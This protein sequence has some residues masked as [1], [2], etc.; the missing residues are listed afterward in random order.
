MREM[1]NFLQK[2]ENAE[3]LYNCI[4]ICYALCRNKY[5][6]LTDNLV[7]RR[8][9]GRFRNGNGIRA[10]AKELSSSGPV[11]QNA[12]PQRYHPSEDIAESEIMMNE[13]TRLTPAETSRTIIEV[14]L[15]KKYMI[16]I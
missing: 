9:D 8:C 15:K 7:G 2:L 14:T 1:I 3:Y 16:F 10:M 12:K 13:A 5:R 6:R 4:V 11:K